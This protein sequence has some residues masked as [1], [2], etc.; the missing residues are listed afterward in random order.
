LSG[1]YVAETLVGDRAQAG[2]EQP[3]RHALGTTAALATPPPQPTTGTNAWPSAP[4]VSMTLDPGAAFGSRYRIESLLGRGGMGQVYKALDLD[5]DRTVA[6]KLIRPD[7]T[8]NPE[9]LQRFKQELLL[10]SRISHKNV[11]RIHD[12]GE[13]SGLK[14][15]SMAYVEG[16]DLHRVLRE[17]GRL[18]IDRTLRLARQLC[19]ALDAA[20]SEG[21]VHRDLKPQ[22]VLIDREDNA[23]VSDFGLAKT[24]EA[25]A[26]E[27]THTG[28][29]LGTPRYMSP[30]QAQG[31]PV[32]ARSD[33]YSLGLML[34]EMVTGSSPFK[35]ES[36]AEVMLQRIRERPK[37]PK[38]LNPDVPDYVARVILRCLETDPYRRYQSA[39]EI[40]ADLDREQ[41][42]R[43]SH[44]SL[45]I[46]LPL[47]ARRGGIYAAL[48]VVTIAVLAFVLFSLR[49]GR[50]PSSAAVAPGAGRLPSLNRGKYLA[51]LPFRVLGN[52]ASLGYLAEGLDESLAAK[53]FSL[54]GVHIVS[55]SAVAKEGQAKPVS[56]IAQ[57]L[58]VNLAVQGSVEAVGGEVAIFVRLQD[59]STGQPM[60]IQEFTGEPKDLLTL[61]DNIS[62][63][64]I[65]HLQLHPGAAE[66]ARATARPTENFAA[67]QP[68]LKG[69][70][71]MRGLPNGR[72]IQSAIDDYQQALK[73]DPSFALAY[74]GLANAS[75][76][77]YRHKKDRFWVE[78]ALTA[79][80]QAEQLSSNLPQVYMALG[81]VYSATGKNAQSIRDLRRAVQLA[82]SS[83]EPYRLLGKAYEANGQSKQAIV[84]LQKAVGIDRY[85]WVNSDELGKA[86]ERAGKYGQAM[87]EFK[88]VVQ[89]EPADAA[90]F[91]NIGAIYTIEG[92][93][94]HAIPSL[95]KAAKL[96]PTFGHYLDLGTAYFY[97]RRFSDAV[98]AFQKAAQLSPNQEM[99]YG[100]L[101]QA[102]LYAGESEKATQTFAEAIGLAYKALQ[103]NPRDADTLADMAEYYAM[104]GEESQGLQF[105]HNAR[106]IS[107]SDP[108]YAYDEAVVEAA[109][110]NQMAALGALRDAL[111]E[112][113]PAQQAALDPELS[114][115]Q[116]SPDFQKLMTG[117]GAKRLVAEQGK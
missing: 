106:S 56:K 52:Q 37:N 29:I 11:L 21:I 67:Y 28:Q 33:L 66:L 85:Y 23:Y 18:P 31:R 88:R 63:G 38:A 62:N 82:P 99:I 57:D 14:F 113:Y 60:W 70:D 74:A 19:A 77:M 42:S 112:G 72:T 1:F 30:E 114:I 13:V 16:E 3:E 59:L 41:A 26:Q 20:H 47:P 54:S 58:G 96:N 24:L 39:R 97:A 115:L 83:D 64:L 78:Q 87:T 81:N 68:Y 10:S 71:L 22:N 12:L 40:I 116:G 110:R 34:F 5:L 91:F 86:Y 9:A 89:L 79:A 100:N 17:Q 117:Y 94:N 61:E 90:G 50:Q 8:S 27:M 43:P 4:A 51:I 49:K 104:Q 84:A 45:Q 95:E 35:G 75:L 6:L 25:G 15:I 36:F 46:N 105:I 48:A 93:Y 92:D 7:L 103:V 111:K 98:T 109:A 2:A 80:Q 101:A 73:Q 32:D 102:Y 53:L 44:S 55:S 76:Q 108:Q 65:D 107:P 69:Q